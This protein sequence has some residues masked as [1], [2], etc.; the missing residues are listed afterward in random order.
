LGIPSHVDET[1][2]EDQ[3]NILGI[4]ID[5]IESLVLSVPPRERNHLQVI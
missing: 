3:A 5:D 4:A 1:H 2:E